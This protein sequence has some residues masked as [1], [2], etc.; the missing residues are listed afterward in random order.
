MPLTHTQKLTLFSLG[1]CLTQLNRRFA[2]APLNVAISKIIF[3]EIA[4]HSGLVEKKERA[5]YKN[6]ETLEEKKLIEYTQSPARNLRF[7]K[8]GLHLYLAMEKEL[9]HYRAIAGFWS[10]TPQTQRKLQ[11]ILSE[12]KLY[13]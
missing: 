3:I 7:T 1:Q 2:D 5:L 13:K 11:T 6:L 12:Q 8:K 10:K 4:M 9:A